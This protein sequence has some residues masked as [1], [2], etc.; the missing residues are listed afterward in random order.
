MSK[1]QVHCCEEMTRHV[2]G[3]EVAIVLNRRFREVGIRILDGG[4]SVQLI[5]FCPW[6]GSKLP[7]SL[8]EQWF[9]EIEALGVDPAT[10]PIPSKYQSDEWWVEL[11][12]SL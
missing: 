10:G 9:D 1:Q 11:E 7:S 5:S 2:S 3:G 12:G 8:R 4:S 6:C